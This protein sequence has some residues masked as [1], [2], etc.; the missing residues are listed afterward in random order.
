MQLLQGLRAAQQVLLVAVVILAQ[1]SENS[2]HRGLAIEALDP[3]VL[4][5]LGVTGVGGEDGGDALEEV[6]VLDEEVGGLGAV[7]GLEHGFQPAD[8]RGGVLVLDGASLVIQTDEM[9]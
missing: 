9:K 5:D 2:Q 6:D 8:T 1:I 4:V 7:L 3:W